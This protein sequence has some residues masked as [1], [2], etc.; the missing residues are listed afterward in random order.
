MRPKTLR[1]VETDFEQKP[2]EERGNIAGF[3]KGNEQ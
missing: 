3:V 1:K 2:A